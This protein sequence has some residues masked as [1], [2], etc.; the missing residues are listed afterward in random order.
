MARIIYLVRCWNGFRYYRQYHSPDSIVSQTPEPGSNPSQAFSTK[1]AAERFVAENTPV[2]LN[3]FGVATPSEEQR[4]QFMLTTE[5]E[6]SANPTV[7]L[8]DL[9]EKVRSL[10]LTP[11]VQALPE[12][13]LSGCLGALFFWKRKTHWAVALWPV[14]T[15]WTDWW[16]AHERHMAEEQK[17]ILW[18]FLIPEPYQIVPLEMED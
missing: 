15:A 3:P 13:Q 10:G 14:I 18:R 9:A 6:K 5:E 7:R 8:S 12:Q 2:T 1:E 17:I 11:P 4:L 16:N